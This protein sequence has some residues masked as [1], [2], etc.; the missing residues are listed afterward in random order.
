MEIFAHAI[1]ASTQCTQSIFLEGGGKAILYPH[2]FGG[3]KKITQLLSLH[4]H[5]LDK[6]HQVWWAGRSKPYVGTRYQWCL[7]AFCCGPMHCK[8]YKHKG[9]QITA[10]F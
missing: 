5:M 1:Y 8:C 2:V 6:T 7:W 9:Y 10:T 4:L 3:K